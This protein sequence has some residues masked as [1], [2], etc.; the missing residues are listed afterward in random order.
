MRKALFA[1]LIGFA[2]ASVGVTAMAQNT[3]YEL[4][5]A[6]RALSSKPRTLECFSTSTSTT[7]VQVQHTVFQ[8]ANSNIVALPNGRSIEGQSVLVYDNQSGPTAVNLIVDAQLGTLI[9]VSGSLPQPN[10]CTVG[11]KMW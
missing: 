7:G 3:G 6:K 2:A 10:T 1:G 11:A 5:I 9:A 8:L 4:D